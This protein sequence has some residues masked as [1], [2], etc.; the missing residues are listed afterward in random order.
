MIVSDGTTTKE[1]TVIG[2]YVDSID[3][4]SD[5][6]SGRAD[7]GAS[8]DVWVHDGGHRTIIAD[9]SGHWTADFSV[10]PDVTDITYD[11]D[12]G[13]Q[14]N[15]A[16]GDSTFVWW[17]APKIQVAPVDDWVQSQNTWTA[18]ATVMLSIEVGGSEV[19]SD[20][21]TSD[22]DG[23][24]HFDMAGNFD[25]ERGQNVI[26]SDGTT[27][28]E[29]TVV[30]LYVDAIDVV[31]E[32]VSGR[33]DPG[34]DV[35][36]WVH[37]GGNRTVTA[38][39]SGNWT[40]EFFGETDL[41]YDSDGGSQ[42]N[43]ADGDSTGVWWS[44]LRF[45][46]SPVDDW[47][48]S[49]NSW[50]PGATVSLSVEDGGG[51]IYSDSQTADAGGNFHFNFGGIF[52]LERGHIVT[53]SDGT[54]TKVHTVVGL[55]VD[56]I[57]VAADT[58]SGR[59]D[60]GADVD[61]WVHD[62][63][64]RTVTADGS[65]NWT[66]DFSVGPDITDLTV[67]SDGGS[68]QNDAD[69][70]STAVW[71]ATPRFEISPV[72]EWV[73]SLSPW[74]PGATIDLTIEDGG[75][76]IYT[77]SQTADSGGNFHINFGHLFDLERGH[78]VTVSDGTTTKVHTVIGLFVDNVDVAADTVSGRTDPGASVSVWGDGGSNLT[79]VADGSGS[80]M[81][82]FSGDTD[83]TYLSEGGASQSDSDGDI[84]NVWWKSPRFQVAPADDWAQST[85]SWVPGAT[86]LLN[87]E[88]GSGVVYSDS[89]TV[90]ANGQF[91]MNFGGAFDL[92]RGHVVSVSD[93][94]TTKEHTV[95]GL[96]VDS[97]DV[98]S[99]RVSGR[100]EVGASVDVWV[101]DGGNR[102]VTTDGS[103]NWT[104]EFSADT[105]IT[106]DSD[107]GSQQNDADGDSTGVWWAAPRIQVAP[108]DDWVQSWSPWMPGATVSLSI[109]DGGGS[110]VYADAQTADGGGN[111]NFDFG[112]IFDLERGHVVTVSDGTTTKVHTV[113]GLFVDTID[114]ASDTVSGRADPG[115][116]V[117]VW[118]HDG[119]S[120]TVTADGSGN[121]TADFSVGP[122]IT[123]LTAFS[124]GGSQQNDAD[125]DSTG[126][127]W[128]AVRRFGASPV[129]DWVNSWNPWVPGTTV[130]L[131]IEVG[132]SVVY[133]DT[134]TTDASGNF[135]FNFGGNFDLERGQK[136]IV[137]DGTTTKEHTVFPLFVDSVDVAADTVS[138]RADPGASVDVW[139]ND[140]GNRTV[141]AD[142]SGNWT[143]DF[144]G[145][146]DITYAS[147][148]GSQQ[149]DVDGDV[150]DV[151]WAAP[152]IQVSPVGDW[153]Q[154][155]SPWTPGATVLLSIEDGGGVVH[156]D[157]RTSDV[158]GN[159]RFNVGGAIDLE[160]GHLVTVTDGATTKEHTVVG[161]FVDSVD[162]VSDTVSGRADAGATVDVWVHDGGN[163]TVTADGSGNWTADFSGDTDLTYDS[164][165]GS[166]QG[167][168]DGDIT[169]VWWATP[170][171]YVS[172]TVTDPA[173][174]LLHNVD[175]RLYREDEWGNWQS[176]FATRTESDG[177]YD[178]RVSEAGTYRVGFYDLSG[179]YR[180][181]FYNGVADVE[182][183]TDIPLVRGSEVSG[184]N[185]KFDL[186]GGEITG[187]VADSLGGPLSG[188]EVTAYRHDGA[189]EWV[190]KTTTD[191]SGS[192]T[193]DGL[194]TDTYRVRFADPS[195]TYAYEYYD[196]AT[197]LDSGQDVSVVAGN[198]VSDINAI[199]DPAA[200]PAVEAT[201]ATGSVTADSRTAEVIVSMTRGNRSDVNIVRTVICDGGAVPTDVVL[202]VEFDG[203]TSTYPMTPISPGSSDY[204][205]TIPEADIT[206]SASISVRKNCGGS[207]DETQVAR[208]ELYDPS[209]YVTDANTGAAIQGATIHL[210][211]VPGWR[212][213]TGLA[214]DDVNTCQSGF[215]KD[216]Q[217]PW[218]QPAPTDEGV[219]AD[220][221]LDGFSPAA[222]PLLTDAE[223][224]YGW[225][226][227]E[228]CW[229]VHAQA[230]GYESLWSPVVGVPPAVTDLDIELTP[231][232]DRRQLLW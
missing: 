218:N 182:N 214:D 120:R 76:V 139:V 209:G 171:A 36:V 91:H 174:N 46:V 6:V 183:A 154:A 211:R 78:V 126:I 14:Q 31:S 55:Y 148:G 133:T 119:G 184:I 3:V 150:T 225:D 77:D 129:H 165:G 21:Q 44:V 37:D 82:D 155:W 156:S 141:T 168:A 88:D 62:G 19:Y 145:D 56:T 29:H 27:T 200:P 137:S 198:T 39:G 116:D 217:D 216:E 75:G 149:N 228:G 151:W 132:G 32:T 42:Q 48:H 180:P 134:Q 71:W 202:M 127:W 197:I 131:S 83:I 177:K 59:A 111:F 92:K 25:L 110:V 144:F 147:D 9:G 61:V 105:D 210:Y 69:G 158:G 178:L 128:S 220:P 140:G 136:V 193:I 117:D 7:A 194:G 191:G 1:H 187:T 173:D 213:R 74:M 85:G 172:G 10:G 101:H 223:G 215:S 98:V 201:T 229:Y 135:H 84:T 181:V 81:A 162:V 146:T 190:S 58:V 219:L 72:D 16:Y 23:R 35:D 109:A 212:A 222:S 118:V 113:V 79:V 51:V 159:F 66:A 70:D 12:G 114:V 47:V 224:H 169:T 13:S 232:S 103:G 18:G 53:V 124:D 121:W 57:D 50:T 38:D 205:A 204:E 170:Q 175:V 24:F 5:T 107:G 226:V 95:I 157:S 80:W 195:N 73:Q 138:G 102:T 30:G 97:V 176:L 208:I 17:G 100:A 112:G 40:A 94:T 196:D 41:T 67:F 125:G 22:A 221:N 26:V 45:Q 153:V 104:A 63:G 123:D 167:D 163:R 54:T 8:V 15:G 122:D 152:R 86:V 90:D 68:Q 115:A 207:Q 203:N 52:D 93:G 33:A 199:L 130:D 20:S 99:D 65:G 186:P 4:V 2:L 11:S 164:D 143:A 179:V 206:D 142:G 189:Q 43:D 108:V 188:I 106:Y 49:S 89:Q 166:Q 227:P 64:S 87:I 161:L 230:D 160:R 231:V 192:Y 60:P 185:A 96:F 28:K 34:A